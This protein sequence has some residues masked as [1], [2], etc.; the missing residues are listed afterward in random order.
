MCMCVCACVCV[1]VCV[2]VC[3]CVCACVCVCV[4]ERKIRQLITEIDNSL[5]CDVC[6]FHEYSAEPP[7]VKV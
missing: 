1:C 5:G 7:L 2:C 4:C 3:M 6:V